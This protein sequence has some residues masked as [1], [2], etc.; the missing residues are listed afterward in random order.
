MK[1]LILLLILYSACSAQSK[2]YV[3]LNGN[4]SNNGTITQP[5]RTF[6]K[7]CTAQVIAAGDSIF[8][9]QGTYSGIANITYSGNASNWI[10]LTNYK[11]EEVKIEGNS[12]PAQTM[13]F[14][15]GRQYL[16]IIGL[17][18]TNSTGNNS[19]GVFIGSTSNNIHV[20]RCRF[21]EINF[22]ANPADVP[23]NST[24]VNPL[25]VCGD[26]TNIAINNILLDGNEVFDCRT[27]YSE[28]ITVSGNV[29]GFVVSNNYVHDLFNIGIVLAGHYNDCSD[30]QARNGIVR[31]NFVYNCQFGIITFPA[32]GIYV[33]GAKDMLIERNRVGKCQVGIQLG[34]ETP[35]K[36][37][38]N[39]IV[40]SNYVYYCVRDGIGVGSSNGAGQV[41]NSSI[42]NNTTY[43]N[44]TLFNYDGGELYITNVDN[45]TVSNN[46][47]YARKHFVGV[48]MKIEDISKIVTSMIDYNIFYADDAS[49]ARVKFG[50]SS[51]S[52]NTLSAYQATTL[53]DQHSAFANPQFIDTVDEQ[54]PEL[55]LKATS[56]AID[57]GFWFADGKNG[58]TDFDENNRLEGIKVDI[59]AYE[60]KICPN[61]YKIYGKINNATAVKFEVSTKIEANNTLKNGSNTQY[62]AGKFIL[63]KPGFRAD[64]GSVFKAFIDGCGNN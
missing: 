39:T 21:S 29:D 8:F 2:Y 62:D 53:K 54:N 35:T 43:Q 13:L 1:T 5:W 58:T 18:F 33:D 4:D 12:T 28:G 31:D 20:V 27:G 57:A 24:N 64:S 11:S 14:I 3:S 42:I 44:S 50:G 10:V 52:L 47:F 30:K 22:S 9:R 59:G 26:N 60:Y 55:H 51:E 16:K 34:C 17:H 19:R 41:L 37:S 32:A 36:T 63:L 48:L 38:T 25:K 45:I 61:A 6:Q 46:I 40:R 7:A 56:P 49:T 15:Y 23:S